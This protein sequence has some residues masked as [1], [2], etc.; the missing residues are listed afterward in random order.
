M[1]LLP[2]ALTALPSQIGSME[3]WLDGSKAM[4]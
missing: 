4:T 3:A 1:F 2:M